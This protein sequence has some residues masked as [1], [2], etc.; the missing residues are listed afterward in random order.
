MEDQGLSAS[1]LSPMWAASLWPHPPGGGGRGSC[2]DFRRPGQ[3]SRED[4]MEG[5][6]PETTFSRLTHPSTPWAP[7]PSTAE[8]CS[9]HTAHASAPERLVP[10]AG[11]GL[12][13]PPP[14][15]Q[16]L[17]GRAGRGCIPHRL[18][19]LR[20]APWYSPGHSPCSQPLRNQK[21]D[22]P[23]RGQGSPALLQPDTARA[24]PCCPLTAHGHGRDP[25][26]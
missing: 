10:C 16:F 12:A 25:T 2:R 15:S 9:S 19:L 23:A 21:R 5:S 3:G 4:V 14:A 22:W 20:E 26:G 1:N 8:S 18:Y 6:T 17:C 13:P 24:P 7:W 11:Q